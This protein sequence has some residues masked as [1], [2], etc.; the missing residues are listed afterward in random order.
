MGFSQRILWL[1]SLTAGLAAA[2]VPA[3]G[4]RIRWSG[5][6]LTE[7]SLVV[8]RR[9]I[10][11]GAWYGIA[12]PLQIGVILAGRAWSRPI[13]GV[14][15]YHQAQGSHA[16]QEL[17]R[18]G[19]FPRTMEV[20]VDLMVREFAAGLRYGVEWRGW[21]GTLGGGGCWVMSDVRR[22]STPSLSQII[23]T[24]GRSG[25]QQDE[26]SGQ[27]PGIWAAASL[28]F[29]FQRSAVGIHLRETLASTA[30]A[31]GHRPA[32]GFQMGAL[33]SMRW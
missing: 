12:D 26:Q 24:Q 33:V 2:V 16:S 1:F 18:D 5:A 3:F 32:G 22:R 19:L 8:G 10:D 23:G 14:V 30:M 7:T 11:S 27:G 6:A 20:D 9:N 31:D 15:S 17:V 13:E 28:A 25:T 4:E 21:Y 29:Q